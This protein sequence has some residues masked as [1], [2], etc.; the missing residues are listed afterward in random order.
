MC[1]RVHACM[2]ACERGG[3]AF[4]RSALARAGKKQELAR[5]ALLSE[6]LAH[7]SSE[8]EVD[9]HVAQGPCRLRRQRVEDIDG[10]VLPLVC[11]R[12]CE[13]ERD[14]QRKDRERGRKSESKGCFFPY[15][16]NST[17]D[18]TI[19]AAHVITSAHFEVDMLDGGRVRGTRKNKEASLLHT[20]TVCSDLSSVESSLGAPKL[21]I[22]CQWL[23]PW[24]AATST[25]WS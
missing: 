23:L 22:Q 7:I 17:H 12:V 24:H 19:A 20:D 10:L 9:H 5:R 16:A 4:N 8:H 11:V 14:R 3:G 13:R 25:V 6:V 15:S 1:A 21:P 2:R 18:M